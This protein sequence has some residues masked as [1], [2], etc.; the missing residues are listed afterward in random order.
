[1][2]P[3]TISSAPKIT[4]A[5]TPLTRESFSPYGTAICPPLPPSV[6][7]IPTTLPSYSS[8]TTTSPRPVLANQSTALKTSPI[9]P[10]QDLYSSSQCPSGIKSE[11]RIS[12]FSCF[13]RH[14]RLRVRETADIADEDVEAN[15][16]PVFDVRVLER[17]PYTT[18]TF[19]PMGL[20]SGGDDKEDGDGGETKYLVIV[21]PSL[22]GTYGD[23]TVYGDKGDNSSGGDG[24]GGTRTSVRDPPDLRNLK[25][26]VAHG[27]QALTYAAGT[28]HAPMVVLGRKRVDFVVVQFVNGVA[29]ED[30]QEVLVEEGVVVEVGAPEVA[31]G[32]RVRKSRL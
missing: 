29:E 1:M 6:N 2:A 32:G 24:G 26:F 17:H 28:W 4:I 7:T 14:L 3:P 27:G 8:S 15:E 21:A 19:I 12:Q 31:Q 22:V 18:Q 20:S 30:C 13:P 5:P 11:P 9:S 23:A 25:A 16:V 10:L